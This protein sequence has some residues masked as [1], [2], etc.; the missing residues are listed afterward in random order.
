MS[1]VSIRT[2]TCRRIFIKQIYKPK[3]LKMTLI[4]KLNDYLD[5]RKL[6]YILQENLIL[7]SYYAE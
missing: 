3:Y 4:D 6:I 2:F 5:T 7:K 1:V